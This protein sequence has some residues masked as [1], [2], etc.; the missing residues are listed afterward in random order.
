MEI[1]EFIRDR[2]N[3]NKSLKILIHDYAGHPF[4]TSLS[5]ELARL[6]HNV[7]HAYFAQD[8]G[9]KGMMSSDKFKFVPISIKKKYSKKNFIARRFGDIEYG[10]EVGK[11]I[12][13]FKP[14]I[15]L[16]GNTPTEAQEII[17]KNSKKHKA[18]F[19]YWCQD[20]YSIAAKLILKKKIPLLG[21]LVGS[22]YS[23]LEKRQMQ[24]AD[25]IVLITKNFLRQIKKWRINEKRVSVIENWGPLDEIKILP[26]ANN[27]SNEYNLDPN[28]IR[29]IY[30][31]TLALKHNPDILINAAKNNPNI[32]ILVV[33]FGVGYDYLCDYPD[34]PENLIL[35]PIQPFNKYS[36]VLA[37]SDFCIAMIEEEA[38]KFSTPSKTLSYLCAGKPILI[39][40]PKDN[41]ASSI[42]IE[43]D[44]GLVF[45]PNDINGIS[46]GI[47]QLM[48]GS[49]IERL[50]AN[51]QIYAKKYFKIED[52]SVRF[53][54][55]FLRLLK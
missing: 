25:H 11:L 46:R 43:N 34:K 55:I 24:K 31:G 39:S 41:L 47:Q 30:T 33:G 45:D 4:Q 9:P 35:L 27:W 38:G 50:S 36:E 10:K 14:N 54:D 15:V 23:F 26:K 49:M 6:G 22:Y 5:K 32:E 3:Q 40:A 7:T 17:L 42:I 21:N 29:G 18:V 44:C 16:S 12:S 8:E 51:S 19:I 48:D 52:I 13:E 1:E 28:K 20:F 2:N 53:L 37:S